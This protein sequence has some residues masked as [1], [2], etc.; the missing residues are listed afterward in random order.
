[1]LLK[2]ENVNDRLLENFKNL[3][4]DPVLI[5]CY[6]NRI[7]LGC[8]YNPETEEKINKITSQFEEHPWWVSLLD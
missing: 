5:E 6:K 2:V 1:M 8:K 4:K 7:Q 3:C